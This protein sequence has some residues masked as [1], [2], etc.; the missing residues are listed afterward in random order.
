VYYL[1]KGLVDAYQQQLLDTNR[2]VQDPDYSWERKPTLF[3]GLKLFLGEALISLGCKIRN[4]S[5]YSRLSNE[6]L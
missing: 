6:C 4:A 3:D 1:T 5:A 2:D